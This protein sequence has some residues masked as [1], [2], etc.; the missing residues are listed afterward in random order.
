MYE[1][2]SLVCMTRKSKAHV[3]L[4]LIGPFIVDHRPLKGYR[5]GYMIKCAV[6]LSK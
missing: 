5:V 2:S 1:M 4:I 3:S 6:V